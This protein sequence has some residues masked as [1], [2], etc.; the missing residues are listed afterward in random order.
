MN[1]QKQPPKFV[2]VTYL[3]Y[4]GSLLICRAVSHTMARRIANALNWYKPNPKG[5]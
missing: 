1:P 3:V 4:R 5:Y 2:A